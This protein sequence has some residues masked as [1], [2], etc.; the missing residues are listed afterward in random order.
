MRCELFVS[1][2]NGLIIRFLNC[3]AWGPLAALV[4]GMLLVAGCGAG[5]REEKKEIIVYVAASMSDVFKQ[6]ASAFTR[7]SG[8]EAGLEF[9]SSG[10]LA[11][12]IEAGAPADVF[13]S[14]NKTWVD[15]LDE[16]RLISSADRKLIA[17]NQLVCIEPA[18]MSS[19]VTEARWLVQ[20]QRISIGN[21]EHVPAGTYARDALIH[22]GIW[23]RLNSEGK[24]VFAVTVRA[25]LA[26]VEQGEVPLGIVFRTD[27]LLTD[28]VK[29]VFAFPEQTH[30]PITYHAA[31]VSGTRKP[32]EARLLLEFVS[33]KAFR[34]ILTENGFL[35]P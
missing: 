4:A 27:A 28:K 25:A 2:Q 15:Y 7:E 32:A 18:G 30:T 22:Y 3:L 13:I 35:L 20:A 10:S 1:T 17:R 34:S 5:D 33:S 26:F 21:P 9:A 31:L 11:R 19:G 6:A 8:I 29:E 24:L 12:K 23:H 16:K 14:A